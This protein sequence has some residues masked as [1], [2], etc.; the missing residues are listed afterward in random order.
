MNNLFADLP[1]DASTE[2]V[3]VLAENPQVRIERIISTGQASAAGFWYDQDEHEWVRT[4]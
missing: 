1:A 4:E 3:T 2:L